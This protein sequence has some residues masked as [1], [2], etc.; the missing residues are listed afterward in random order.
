MTLVSQSSKNKGKWPESL[1]RTPD[2][3]HLIDRPEAVNKVFKTL[4]RY[5]FQGKGTDPLIPNLE[6]GQRETELGVTTWRTED[7]IIQDSKVDKKNSKGFKVLKEAVFYGESYKDLAP[8]QEKP[9]E[10][11]YVSREFISEKADV[12][13]TVVSK[14][15]K[16]L[17]AIGDQELVDIKRPLPRKNKVLLRLNS[18]AFLDILKYVFQHRFFELSQN[19]EKQFEHFAARVFTPEKLFYWDSD[20]EKALN[21]LDVQILNQMQD[22]YVG[23]TVN[24]EDSVINQMKEDI[25]SKIEEQFYEEKDQ[26]EIHK[27]DSNTFYQNNLLLNKKIMPLVRKTIFID[28]IQQTVRDKS[29]DSERKLLGYLGKEVLDSRTDPDQSVTEDIVTHIQAEF[30]QSDIYENSYS[31]SALSS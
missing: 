17:N 1:K 2:S 30:D 6:V 25:S 29:L 4:Y 15:F 18:E 19:E 24:Q 22:L 16:A 31:N 9:V 21:N 27:K 23:Y 10:G 7:G 26:V 14:A 8:D 12:N 28:Q 13:L 20:E 5:T 11:K 3:Q